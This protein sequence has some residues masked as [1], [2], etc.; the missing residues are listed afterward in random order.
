MARDE[1]ELDISPVTDAARDE[2]AGGDPDG[3]VHVERR[4]WHTALPW[5]AVATA[6]GAVGMVL[7]AN[8]PPPASDTPGVV[9][10]MSAPPSLRW[11][12]DLCEP[13]AQL[14]LAGDLLLVL[15]QSCVQALDL[16]TGDELWRVP[17]LT[18]ARCDYASGPFVACL[19]AD[20]DASSILSIELSTGLVTEERAEG[21]GAVTAFGHGRIESVVDDDE[22]VIR[23][24]AADG[25]Q[26][27]SRAFE[28]AA[29]ELEVREA[30]GFAVVGSVVVLWSVP[31]GPT[32]DV[33][34]GSDVELSWT[35]AVGDL[36]AVGPLDSERTLRDV[37]G[38]TVATLL[39]GQILPTV[40]DDLEP[41]VVLT[42]DQT[43]AEMERS[44]RLVARDRAGTALWEPPEETY[45]LAATDD[46]VVLLPMMSSDQ[47]PMVAHDLR[48]GT[49]LWSAPA[50]EV[51]T[52]FVG[53]DGTRLLAGISDE[54][55]QWLTALD[56]TSGEEAWRV[57]VGD[58]TFY[59]VHTI[60]SDGSVVVESARSVA[61]WR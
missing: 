60:A 18:L 39:P 13:D 36:V 43:D 47:T 37:D 38:R 1:I 55:G 42:T 12:A 14:N 8:V 52:W 32:L 9:P 49:E 3:P 57:Q 31:D 24:L 27:W 4:P 2:P 16:E 50:A 59:G 30:G 35:G 23:R 61:V 5:V 48:T 33:E 45:P 26:V 51:G 21:V 20:G 34:D 58:T 41:D 46:V 11:E 10:D 6:L 54:D 19:T 15:G 40:T 44:L 29:P 25:T 28:S 56:V 7:A 17:D 53:T 22:L